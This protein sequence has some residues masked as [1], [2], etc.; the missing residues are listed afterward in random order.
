[1]IKSVHTDIQNIRQIQKYIAD[2]KSIMSGMDS[3]ESLK[4]S[5]CEKYA[6]T[7]LITN[8]TECDKNLRDDSPV[9]LPQLR[10]LRNVSSHNYMGVDFKVVWAIC[11][12]LMKEGTNE[13]LKESLTLLKNTLA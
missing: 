1:M 2:I 3:W 4:N 10:R 9:Q 11:Q 12:E 13:C 6:I 7:Q 5:L 8:V